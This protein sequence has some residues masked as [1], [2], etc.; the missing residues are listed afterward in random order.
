M[1]Q[2]SYFSHEFVS[3]PSPAAMIKDS[4]ES[5]LEDRKEVHFDPQTKAEGQELERAG[6]IAPADRKH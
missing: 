3:S 6:H 4:D 2:T 1:N 5:N